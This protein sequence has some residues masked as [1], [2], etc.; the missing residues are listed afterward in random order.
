MYKTAEQ[1]INAGK[2]I[3]KKLG[4]K[5][6]IIARSYYKRNDKRFFYY[7]MT[8]GIFSISGY[9]SKW[10]K[11]T[12]NNCNISVCSWTLNGAMNQLYKRYEKSNTRIKNMLRGWK[13]Y[14]IKKMLK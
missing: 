5:W 2:V 7:Y 13:M 1:A 12:D 10:F 6:N 8:R 11:I 9:N 4:G 3:S 14:K